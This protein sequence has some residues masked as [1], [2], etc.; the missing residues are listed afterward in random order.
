MTDIGI[1]LLVALIVA[2]LAIA[3]IMAFILHNG[4]DCQ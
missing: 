4:G 2:L 3:G 1:G